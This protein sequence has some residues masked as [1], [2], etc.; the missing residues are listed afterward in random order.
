MDKMEPDYINLAKE[1]LNDCIKTMGERG[2][3]YGESWRDVKR[4]TSFLDY[5]NMKLSRAYSLAKIEEP[6]SYLVEKIYDQLIDTINYCIF[7]AIRIKEER[8]NEDCNNTTNGTSR[9]NE[10]WG[11]TNGVTYFG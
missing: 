9:T 3:M 4:L 7:A 6:N 2:E 8:K 10:Q 11:H 1:L 5:I